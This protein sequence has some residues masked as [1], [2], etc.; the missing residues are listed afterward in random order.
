MVYGR[1]VVRFG[2]LVVAVVRAVF[3]LYWFVT[4]VLC[5]AVL[6]SAICLIWSG[7]GIARSY[8]VVLCSAYPYPSV[9][10]CIAYLPVLYL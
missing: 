10:V 3:S 7:F 2:A 9:G 6:C 5:S 8:V 1:F 4:I